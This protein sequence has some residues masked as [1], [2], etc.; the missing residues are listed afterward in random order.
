MAASYSRQIPPGGTG[1]ITINVK[2][3]GKAGE[4]IRYHATVYTNDPDHATIELTM[5][6]GVILP[7]EIAPKAARLIGPAGSPIETQVKITPPALNPFDIKDAKAVRGENITFQLV[8]QSAAEE[9]YFL[10]QISNIK[11]ESGRY[12]DQIILTTT[13]PLSPELVIRV[14]GLIRD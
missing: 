5:T 8:N 2:T 10:L 4:T 1:Q 3:D 12:S 7:A 11:K 9:P 6:G 14:Y 13:S